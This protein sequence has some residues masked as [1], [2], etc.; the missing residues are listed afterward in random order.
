MATAQREIRVEDAGPCRKKISVT[1]PAELVNEHISSAT[2]TIVAGATLPGFRR[3]RAPRQLIEKRFGASIRGEAKQQLVSAAYSDA[4]QANNL[5][6]IGEPE[7]GEGF[8]EMEVVEGKPLSFTVEVEIAPE[9]ELPSLEGVQVYKPAIEVKDEMVDEQIAKLGLNEGE[10]ESQD[11]A[12][13][14]DYCIGHGVM[15]LD[16]GEVL[17]DVPD[18]VVQVPPDA[19][20]PRG[21][22]LG[23]MVDDFGTQ[24]GTPKPG[25]TF[26]VK[27]T[28]PESHENPRVRGAALTI[29][30][31]VDRV[32]R[33]IPAT[34][35]QLVERFGL[36]SVQALRETMT[37]RLN[38]RAMLEQQSVMRQQV[39]KHLI[40]T[41]DFELPEKVSAA[42]AERN[43]SRARYEMMYRGLDAQAVEERIAELRSTSAD[44]ARRQL[45]LFFILAKIASERDVR[46]TEQEI[47]GRIH[48]IAQQRGLSPNQVAQ[49][50]SRNNQIGAIAQQIR[51]HK[52]LDA[53]IAQAK[54][55]EI[56]LDEFNAKFSKKELPEA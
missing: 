42:Q 2:S 49:E 46:V 27:T 5:R 52:V 28:G 17:I 8:A 13:P 33:I 23:V 43:I 18:A 35:E 3:G 16:S 30:F 12:V 4:V 47:Y 11:Q 55:E 53:L 9:F 48:Q 14:G 40:D 45:K 32:E 38:Q 26:V 29:E 39:A 50:L 51:E 7:P 34:P 41:I 15:K 54:V 31:T 24:I 21:A 36:E 1:V 44:V 20:Q 37:L 25:D 56:P 6:V 10:L 22:I 19:S